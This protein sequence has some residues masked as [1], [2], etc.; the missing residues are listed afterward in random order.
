[1]GAT[2]K[3]L[4]L[5][6]WS[7]T[8]NELIWSFKNRIWV[9]RPWHLTTPPKLSFSPLPPHTLTWV[10]HP[11]I[12]FSTLLVVLV[13]RNK[14]FPA[15]VIQRHFLSA[16]VPLH[17]SGFSLDIS[18]IIMYTCILDG[19]LDE[20][21]DE[22]NE[23]KMLYAAIKVMDPNTNLPKIVFIN[24]VSLIYFFPV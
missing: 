5:L 12:V 22:L 7:D 16:L 23:G 15:Y 4:F 6:A 20:L 18:Y 1:M 3:G 21:V 8:C 9:C 13:Y 14:M 24:W 11:L 17:H 19:D 10:L 2:K